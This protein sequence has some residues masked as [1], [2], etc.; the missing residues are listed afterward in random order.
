MSYYFNNISLK[1]RERLFDDL[2]NL[3]KGDLISYVLDGV[4]NRIIYGIVYICKP[5]ISQYHKWYDITIIADNRLTSLIINII[6]IGRLKK[7]KP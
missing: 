3:K 1:D 5:N 4:P 2:N 7:H 6:N